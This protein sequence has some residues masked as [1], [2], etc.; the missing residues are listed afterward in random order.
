MPEEKEPEFV[1]EE[2]ASIVD[3]NGDIDMTKLD[4]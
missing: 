1:Y 2:P 4:P 3:E